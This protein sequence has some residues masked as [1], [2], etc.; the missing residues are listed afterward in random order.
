MRLSN[1]RCSAAC[2]LLFTALMAF[3]WS[4]GPATGGAAPELSDPAELIRRAESAERDLPRDTFD[5]AAVVKQ[6][7]REPA[8]LFEWVRDNTSWAPYAGCLRGPAGVLMDRLGSNLDRALLLGELL[9]AAGATGV[10]LERGT[11]PEDRAKQLAAAARPAPP[12]PPVP[13]AGAG[14]QAAPAADTAQAEIQR[15][16]ADVSGRSAALSESLRA[17]LAAAA[18]GA[19]PAAAPPPPHA[20][21]PWKA[22]V[23][24]WWVKYDR[25]GVPTHLDPTAADARPGARPAESAQSFELP[26]FSDPGDG[27]P[28]AAPAADALPAEQ[29]HEVTLRVVVEQARDGKLKEAVALTRTL[30]PAM[31]HGHRVVLHHFPLAPPPQPPAG[32]ASTDVKTSLERYKA[33]VLATRE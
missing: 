28:N 18:P 29:W 23:D 32:P 7:G 13:P 3:A 25:D 24:H 33:T 4:G 27:M 20:A 30:R 19:P 22:L 10:R 2:R 31:L 26:S 15:L 1:D 5:P 6:V 14:H 9:R 17:A 8:K 12:A 21:E 16:A 11:L